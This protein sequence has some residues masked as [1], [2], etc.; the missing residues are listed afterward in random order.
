MPFAHP[1]AVVADGEL[2]GE[3]SIHDISEKG[4][5]FSI[6][7]GTDVPTEFTLVLSKNGRVRRECQRIWRNGSDVGASFVRADSR[8]GQG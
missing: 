2:I 4:V 7:E 5:Q 8:R 1:G 3:C 6:D